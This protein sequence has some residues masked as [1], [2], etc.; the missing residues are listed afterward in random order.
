MTPNEQLALWAKGHS[1]HNNDTALPGG[2]CC[3][4]FSCCKPELRASDSERLEFMSASP[5][6][7]SSMLMTFLGRMLESNFGH[8]NVSEINSGF[9]V[10]KTENPV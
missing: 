10:R 5:A 9:A 3:P 6:R 7:R 8:E 4:D 1:I 2:E